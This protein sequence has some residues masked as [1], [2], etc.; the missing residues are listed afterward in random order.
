MDYTISKDRMLK[1]VESLIKTIEPNF[2]EWETDT[3]TFSN[4][5]DTYILYYLRKKDITNYTHNLARF[6]VWRKE[7]QLNRNVF[8][9]LY[10]YLGDDLMTFVIDWFNKEFDQ[11][12]EFVTF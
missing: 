10:N 4:G 7:L 11:D 6:Y 3:S 2:N 12:A 8:D 5:D 1:L 9:T